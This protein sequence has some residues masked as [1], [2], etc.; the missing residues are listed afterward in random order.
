MD[1]IGARQRMVLSQIRTNK[2][3]DPFVIDS[4]ATLPRE[5]FVPQLMRDTAYRDEDLPI[6]SDRY[7]MEPMVLARLLQLACIRPTDVVLDIGCATGYSA[8]ILARLAT[9]VIALESDL[10]LAETAVSVLAG[11]GIDNVAVITAPL[12]RG[13]VA[14]APYDVIVFEGAVDSIPREIRDQLDDG[15]RLVALVIQSGLFATATL[16]KRAGHVFSCRTEFE[17][18]TAR[19]PGFERAPGFVF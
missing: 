14:Q 17:A 19:L 9:T 11:Q 3:T 12:E 4:L 2:V 5:V 13:Y 8:G 10:R 16:V 6:G 1:F 15:G 7:L 18:S